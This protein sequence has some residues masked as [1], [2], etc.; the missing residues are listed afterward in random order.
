LKTTKHSENNYM[1]V[2]MIAS[3]QSK[4]FDM[5]KHPSS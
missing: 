1:S 5:T 2:S 3:W 4:A